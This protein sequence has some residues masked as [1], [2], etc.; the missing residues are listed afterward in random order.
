M[1]NK[2]VIRGHESTVD[3][4]KTFLEKHRGLS[5]KNSLKRDEGMLFIFGWSA[6]RRFWMKGMLI[7]IDIIWIQDGKVVGIT[8][9]VHPEPGVSMVNLTTYPSPSP[10]DHVLEIPAGVAGEVGIAVGDPVSI[11]L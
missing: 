9:N 7:P 6:V 11:R 1:G 2:V 4:A 3:V 5:G 8:E 10:V